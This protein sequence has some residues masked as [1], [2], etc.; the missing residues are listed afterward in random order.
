[1]TLSHI[2]ACSINGVIGKNGD[3]PWHIP[4][5]LKYFKK[6]TSGHILIMGR[7]TFESFPG[8]LKNRLH[9]IITRN[10][11]YTAMGA[12]VATGIEQAL[13]LAKEN[14]HQYPGEVFI[15]GGGEVYRQT[16]DT[17]QRTYVTLVDKYVDGD[18]LYPIEKLEN[19][20][21]AWVEKHDEHDPGFSF[22]RYDRKN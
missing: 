4:E 6:V 11:K 8:L 16:I 22:S 19:F 9:I 7:K 21:L 20:E 13:A 17:V 18:T 5:D 3:L 10:P 1:M 15:V 12:L 2:V 14:S